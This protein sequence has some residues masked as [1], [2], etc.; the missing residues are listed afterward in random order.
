MYSIQLRVL[1]VANW[2]CIYLR[3]VKCS[4]LV[5]GLKNV[6]IR[7]DLGGKSIMD[8]IAT[9][10]KKADSVDREYLWDEFR[11]Q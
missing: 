10:H 5:D 11:K 6:D 3:K 4:G 9:Y 2:S 8:G 7:E 1:Y